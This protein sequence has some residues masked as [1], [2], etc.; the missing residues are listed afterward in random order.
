MDVRSTTF[1]ETLSKIFEKVNYQ[2]E[3]MMVD[4]ELDPEATCFCFSCNEKDEIYAHFKAYGINTIVTI[5]IADDEEHLYEFSDTF[6][7]DLEVDLKFLL[8]IT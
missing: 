7:Q 2:F 6:F 5:S 8:G 1:Q 3:C 4:F